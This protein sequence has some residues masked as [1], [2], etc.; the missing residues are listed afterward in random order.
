MSILY[1]LNVTIGILAAGLINYGT[2]F[3]KPDGWRISLG[4]ACVPAII[5]TIGA[6]VRAL[7]LV[8]WA[9]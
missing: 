1:Q 7:Y 3:V 9:D 5:I 4:L 2:D 6:I 8:H